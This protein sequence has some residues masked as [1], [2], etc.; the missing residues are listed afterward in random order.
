MTKAVLF[1]AAGTLF[2]VRGSVGEAYAMVAARHGAHADPAAIEQRFRAAFED[3]PPLAFPGTPETELPQREYAWWKRLAGVVFAD[4]RFADFEAF[5]RDLFDYFAA[6]QAWELFA[7]VRPALTILKA[8]GLRLAVVSNFD[9]RLVPICESLGIADLFETLV[10]SSRVGFAKPDQRIF[11]TALQRLGVTAA[12]A[13]HVG[14]SRREDIEGAHAAGMRG[15]LV[16]RKS[17]RSQTTDS[18]HDLGALVDQVGEVS[19]AN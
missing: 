1:D 17:D 15:I 5:F 19:V 4:C 16:E 11:A 9:V 18:V 8:R 3:M 6:A 10:I 13:A 12:E 2:R 14:D 7:D